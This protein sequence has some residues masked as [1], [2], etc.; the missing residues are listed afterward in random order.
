M[1]S[2]RLAACSQFSSV[3]PKALLSAVRLARSLA[4][5]ALEPNRI[6]LN[7]WL[8][9]PPS[10]STYAS[11]TIR[12]RKCITNFDKITVHNPYKATE[13]YKKI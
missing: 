10:L 8:E 4:R 6:E 12:N 2:P 11:D 9:I 1:V 13:I 5:V 7:F 3:E